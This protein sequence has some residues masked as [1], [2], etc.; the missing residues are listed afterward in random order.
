MEF[1]SQEIERINENSLYRSLG[2]RVD[3][4]T[5]GKARSSL[6]PNPAHC[7]PFEGRPHGGV[8]FTLMDTTMAWAVLSGVDQEMGCATINM[9]I[10]YI[11]RA[12]DPVLFCDTWVTHQGG[13]MV[14]T[15]GNIIDEAD[16]LLATGQGVFRLVKRPPE[17]V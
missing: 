3:T 1:S 6:R 2:I 5:G 17:G 11:R 13:R 7:W 4:I 9:D 16:Q 12:D 10:Q 14:Y 8:L 15:R